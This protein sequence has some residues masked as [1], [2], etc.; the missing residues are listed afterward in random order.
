MATCSACS[1]T[2]NYKA[3]VMWQW[4]MC[5]IY[6]IYKYIPLLTRFSSGN[7]GK[8]VTCRLLLGGS[9]V[10]PGAFRVNLICCF[11]PDSC[12]TLYWIKCT[13]QYWGEYRVGVFEQMW[14]YIHIPSMHPLPLPSRTV[15][16][17]IFPSH[18]LLFS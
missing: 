17:Q 6:N 1:S 7:S 18:L 5:N 3:T 4:S 16:R 9:V 11:C 10:E 8:P 12:K 13:K 14:P 2:W 15:L